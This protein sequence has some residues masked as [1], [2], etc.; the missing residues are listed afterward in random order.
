MCAD[1]HPLHEGHRLRGATG[2]VLSPT[3]AVTSAAFSLNW[4]RS[5]QWAPGAAPGM[6]CFQLG[7]RLGGCHVPACPLA[8][9]ERR[10]GS[11]CWTGLGRTPIS[12]VVERLRRDQPVRPRPQGCSQ[13]LGERSTQSCPCWKEFPDV[14]S[15]VTSPCSCLGSPVV[16]AECLQVPRPPLPP[17]SVSASRSASVLR[18]P[19]LQPSRCRHSGPLLSVISLCTVSVTCG[20]PEGGYSTMRYCARETRGHSHMTDHGM[21]L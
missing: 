11:L 4:G 14:T 1:P 2:S 3:P 16:P 7:G 13:G 12:L 18:A 15:V 21:L 17:T 6:Q 5:C 10:R 20:Q 19:R 8:G 9:M